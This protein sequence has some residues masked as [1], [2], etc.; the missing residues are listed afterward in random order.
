[1]DILKVYSVDSNTMAVNINLCSL[2]V[3]LTICF[4]I[5][6]VFF[7]Y[8]FKTIKRKQLKVKDIKFSFS[9]VDVSFEVDTTTQRLAYMLW[10]EIVTR[11]IG[12]PYE[13]DKDVIVE[14]YNSWYESFKLI[15]S[16]L[17]EVDP[18]QLENAKVLIDITM[19]ILNEGMRPHLTTWQAK[20]RA[21]YAEEK[22]K[23]KEMTPQ[24]IQRMYPEYDAL[25]KDLRKANEDMMKFAELVKEIAFK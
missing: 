11:K 15:R 3:V 4:L 20:F 6:D 7:P 5:V 18:S 16:M 17:K 13:E 22:D 10:I 14:V 2:L 1:M 25:I 12:L 23:H 19:G 24:E 9:N 21:W 8:A